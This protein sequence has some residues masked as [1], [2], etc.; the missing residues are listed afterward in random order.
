MMT[1]YSSNGSDNGIF[2]LNYTAKNDLTTTIMQYF[3]FQVRLRCSLKYSYRDP[4][5]Y[6]YYLGDSSLIIDLDDLNY[7]NPC[8]LE[9]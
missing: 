2:T 9:I 7:E 4:L 6:S 8:N 1:I 5:V 3:I